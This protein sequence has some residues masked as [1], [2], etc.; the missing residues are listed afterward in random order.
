VG[1]WA[2]AATAAA[3][4]WQ[5]SRFNCVKKIFSLAQAAVEIRSVIAGQ[6]CQ[7]VWVGDWVPHT[8][9]LIDRKAVS[10]HRS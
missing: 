3:L 5:P 10:V 8:D 7:S 4:G 1:G 9:R 2:V 6:R